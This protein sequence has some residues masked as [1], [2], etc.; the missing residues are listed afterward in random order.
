MD[1]IQIT[2]ATVRNIERLMAVK[3][4]TK[5]KLSK[6]TGIEPPHIS[7]LMGAERATSLDTVARVATALG[8]RPDQLL[9]PPLVPYYSSPA[10]C[11][12]PAEWTEGA[13]P[14]SDW[15][16]LSTFFGPP[17]ELFL[18]VAKGDSMTG[19]GIAEGDYLVI[20]RRSAGEIGQR[21][22]ALVG[23][24]ATLKELAKDGRKLILR[25]CS[26]DRRDKHPDIPIGPDTVVLGHLAG[27]IR[28]EKV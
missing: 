3:G 14:P 12:K 26:G 13:P 18:V 22:L 16:N 9:G 7:R 25:S 21:V 28:K 17:D 20:R 6:A 15:L 2:A 5:A 19:A 10:Q 24:A 27:V 1:A 8:V 4:W 11:G 23:G